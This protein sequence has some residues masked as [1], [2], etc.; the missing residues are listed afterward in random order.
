MSIMACEQFISH[1]G[2][3]WA[4]N[5]IVLRGKLLFLVD[6]FNMELS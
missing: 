1:M 5:A 3:N 6:I 2:Y 4:I